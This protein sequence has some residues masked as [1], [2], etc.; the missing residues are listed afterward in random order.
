MHNNNGDRTTVIAVCGKGGVGKTSI[1]AM[2]T[3]ILIDKGSKVLVIDA[4]PAV[5]LATAIGVGVHKTVDQIR[6]D[7][8]RQVGNKGINRHDILSWLDYEMLMA[9]EENRNLAFLAIGRPETDGCYCQVNSLLKEIIASIASSFH[10]VVIDGEAGIE[11]VNRRVMEKVTHLILVSDA[12]R[13]GLQ[14]AKTILDVSMKTIDFEATGLIINKLKS[15][16]EARNLKIPP[17]ISYLG[18]LPEDDAI[19]QNDID[20]SS[21]LD[22][23]AS[24]AFQ[25]LQGCVQRLGIIELKN[26]FR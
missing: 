6:H 22:L 4:D 14:V 18:W 11:Q 1:S 17:E 15:E 25:S 24:P 13:K 21:L 23:Q 26:P 2:I 19:R 7:L 8:V 16:T 3:K 9:L 12:S 5:G 20:G 10:Y